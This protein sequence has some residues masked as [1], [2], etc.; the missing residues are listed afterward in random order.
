MTVPTPSVYDLAK[1]QPRTFAYYWLC[2]SADAGS[3]AFLGEEVVCQNDLGR[4]LV[5][6]ILS[7]YKPG[8]YHADRKWYPSGAQF[9]LGDLWLQ[10]QRSYW[11]KWHDFNGDNSVFRNA[12]I[13]LG[14]MNLYGDPSLRLPVLKN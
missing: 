1:N 7:N 13:Y 14:I 5:T 3:I 11:K 8:E 4:D 10:G 12:R 6:E 2:K 9:V